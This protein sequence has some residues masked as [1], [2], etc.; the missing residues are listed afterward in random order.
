MAALMASAPQ[1]PTF[2]GGAH[3]VF[4][5]AT[6]V[7]ESHRLVPNLTEQD[8]EVL[9]DGKPQTLTFFQNDI[10]PITIVVM[11]DRSG[12][13]LPNFGL[14]RDAAEQFVTTLLPDDRARV[15]SFSSRVQIDPI[16]FTSDHDVLNN[17]LRTRLQDAGP[18]PLWNAT[19][20]AM[21]A[22]QH[23]E[24]RRVVLVFTDGVDNP[25]R[26]GL[27]QSLGDVIE[28]S[29][30]EEDM[31]YAIGLAD[32]CASPAALAP[33]GLP[34]PSVQRGVR[35]QRGG[36]PGPRGGPIGGPPP[37]GGRIGMP[38]NGPPIG[39][40][41]PGSNGRPPNGLPGP[42][43]VVGAPGSGSG[44]DSGRI[45]SSLTAPTV[46]CGLAHP[47]G[48][49]KILADESGGGYFELH[50]TDNLHDTFTRVSDELHHQYLMAFTPG[51]LDGKLHKLEVHMRQSGMQAR[52]RKTYLATP[53]R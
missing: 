40:P 27:S 11:L 19:F 13:M 39:F 44:G 24:G 9:D 41:G 3:T 23:E 35:F 38:P 52:A 25:G 2:H 22:L 28:R 4:V 29:Q 6:V 17:I 49:L 45:G 30:H 47:D 31:V 20:A 32:P 50:G 37:G 26:V 34:S 46:T 48:G 36:R 7:D 43:D 33:A 51:V 42:T 5:Y 10:Q 18:T 16:D 21:T 53:D 8:F 12:S 1:K 14:V 15:G